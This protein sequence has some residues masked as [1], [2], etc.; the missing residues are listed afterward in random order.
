MK[1]LTESLFDKDLI[2]KNQSLPCGL[3]IKPFDWKLCQDYAEKR[4]KWYWGRMDIGDRDTLGDI[5]HNSALC[6]KS[7]DTAV[8]ITKDFDDEDYD[9]YVYILC[10]E[11]VY[12]HYMYSNQSD[13]I[14][15][16]D[17]T[18]ANDFSIHFGVWIGNDGQLLWGETQNDNAGRGVYVKQYMPATIDPKAE[19]L[20]KRILKNKYYRESFFKK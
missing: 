9:A 8:F 15:L 4:I 18:L 17:V 12:F 10:P 1:S 11:T 20:I 19:R 3:E 7:K 16:E 6:Y 14:H 13:P 2:Q 5:S